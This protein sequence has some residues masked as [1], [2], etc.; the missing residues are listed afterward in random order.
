MEAFSDW[1]VFCFFLG[2]GLSACSEL[3]WRPMETRRVSVVDGELRSTLGTFFGL[4]FLGEGSS[5][6]SGG[7]RMKYSSSHF[8]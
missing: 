8:E 2:L 3:G 5:S 6:S 1:L 7:E 4:F